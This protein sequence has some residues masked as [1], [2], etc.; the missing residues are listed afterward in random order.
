MTTTTT[1]TKLNVKKNDQ[2]LVRAGKDRG[3]RGRVLRVLASQGKAIVERVNMVKKHTR[4]NPQKGVQGGILERA[5]VRLGIV[6]EGRGVVQVLDGLAAG[7]Q[8][9]V[10]N[11]GM[12]GAGM[13]V[14]LIGGETRPATPGA[15]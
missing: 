14:Q 13:Q 7:D 9:V 12:L 6:D 5:A 4:A 2:V 3:S 1:R 15:R 10:G 11:V 8:V